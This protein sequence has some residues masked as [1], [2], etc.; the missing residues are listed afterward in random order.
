MI[1]L[2]SNLRG[3]YASIGALLEAARRRLPALGL[4]VAKASS[5][6]RSHAWPQGAGPDFLNGVVVVETDLGPERTLAILAALELEFGRVRGERNEARTLDLD[7]IAHGRLIWDSVT[8]QLPH[9]RAHQ[10][11][12]VMGPLAEIA[13]DWTHPTLNLTARA[14]SARARVGVDA[15][16]LA[17][18]GTPV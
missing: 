13:P 11:R 9:P 7:L 18:E 15:A 14:L 10:R 12:F 8:L 2:G 3:H 16:S 6:W 4:N 17:P 1:A 5:W